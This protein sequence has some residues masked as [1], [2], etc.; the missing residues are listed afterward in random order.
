MNHFTWHHDRFP[1]R[2]PA[3]PEIIAVLGVALDEHVVGNDP[4]PDLHLPHLCP[5]LGISS[6][7][8]RISGPGHGSR[9]VLRAAGSQHVHGR[10][11]ELLPVVVMSHD[12]DMP[13]PAILPCAR[14]DASGRRIFALWK[15]YGPEAERLG[16]DTDGIHDRNPGAK[17]ARDRRQDGDS[18]SPSDRRPCKPAIAHLGVGA[19]M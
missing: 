12:R 2:G 11:V 5:Y 14:G 9:P 3:A 18:S 6:L 13:R 17:A 19:Q 15:R 4:E 1:R 16:A 8:W 10:G 7:I